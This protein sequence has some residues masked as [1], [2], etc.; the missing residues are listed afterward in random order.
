VD[1][2]GGVVARPPLGEFAELFESV[3]ESGISV[4]GSL[5]VK[6]FFK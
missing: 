1:T 2:F 3:W 4:T 6:V 5:V